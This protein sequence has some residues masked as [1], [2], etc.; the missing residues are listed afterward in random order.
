MKAIDDAY[1]SKYAR[2]GDTYLQPMLA[3]QAIATTL[4]LTP[5]ADPD[6]QHHE[7]GTVMSEEK[8]PSGAKK[9]F[10]EFAPGF[11]HFTDDVLF[12]QV[13][14]RTELPP[15][16]RSLVTVSVLAALGA[17]E[18]LAYH[19]GLAKQNGNTETELKEAIT[20]IAFYAGWPRAMSAMT[21][22]K[23]VFGG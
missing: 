20:H 22:A 21:V 14:P 9:A 18:Q 10:G 13:W 5:R 3:D 4:Q 17:S 2:Y 8:E 6:H 15:K 16:E 7:K 19:L 23:Q 12:G 11:V 1:R